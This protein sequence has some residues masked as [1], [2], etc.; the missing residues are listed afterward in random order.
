MSNS[1][2][3]IGSKFHSFSISISL[4]QTSF[5]VFVCFVQKKSPRRFWYTFLFGKKYSLKNRI[6][7]SIAILSGSVFYCPRHLIQSFWANAP[8]EVFLYFC[9]LFRPAGLCHFDSPYQFCSLYFVFSRRILP[10]LSNH[11]FGVYGFFP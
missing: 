6:K 3:V 11:C 2:A 7:S 5:G 9:L 8:D 10:N 1:S 4:R